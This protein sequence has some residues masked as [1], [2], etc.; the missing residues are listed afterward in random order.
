MRESPSAA[1]FDLATARQLSS[2]NGTDYLVS[3]LIRLAFIAATSDC[4][5]LR[6]EGLRLLQLLI[7]CFADQQEPEFPG[8]S[9]LE[10]YQDQV[11]I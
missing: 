10:Q 6:M 1:H 7:D 3:D 4:D 2:V 5:A 8:H 11:I 9:I